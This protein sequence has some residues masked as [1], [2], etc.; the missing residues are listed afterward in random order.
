[1]LKISFPS[2]PALTIKARTT[3]GRYCAIGKIHYACVDGKIDGKEVPPGILIYIKPAFYGVKEPRDVYEYAMANKKFPHETT[4]DQFFTESQFE[5][6]RILGS[7]IMEQIG[8]PNY[9]A[10]D[11]DDFKNQSEK[12]LGV[13]QP[14]PAR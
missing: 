5:S 4:A 3:G 2:L 9:Q 6:Y 12:H 13:Y 10:K 7:H 11:F 14:K 8:G 1:S